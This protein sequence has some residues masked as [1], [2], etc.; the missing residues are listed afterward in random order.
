M[1]GPG[2]GPGPGSGVGTHTTLDSDDTRQEEDL[3]THCSSP[4]VARW[5]HS[6]GSLKTWP[7]EQ[8]SP[9]PL[10]VTATAATLAAQVLRGKF[11]TPPRSTLHTHSPVVFH[12]SCPFAQAPAMVQYSDLVM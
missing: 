8:L 3:A 4:T 12:I 10:M 7:K 1:A 9:V 5:S 2:A 6:Q 11:H